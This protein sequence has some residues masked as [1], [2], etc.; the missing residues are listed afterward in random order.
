MIAEIVSIEKQISILLSDPGLV[1]HPMLR[2][3]AERAIIPRRYLFRLIG[4]FER[5]PYF[6]RT[7]RYILAQHWGVI[8]GAYSYGELMIPGHAS[9]GL[10][11]GRYVSIARGV[12]W[13]GDH[14]V[15]RLSTHP[16]FYVSEMGGT[17][18]SALPAKALRIEH[19]AWIGENAI[20]TTK[21]RYP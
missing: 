9:P 14:P 12:R 7:L 6:S 19:D 5:G 16:I 4:R 1:S 11:I 17:H 21:Q 3:L 18:E 10:I 20:I 13:V 8:A 2:L 15:D